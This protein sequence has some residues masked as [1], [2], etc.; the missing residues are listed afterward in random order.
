MS[1]YAQS[2]CSETTQSS[3]LELEVEKM[4]ILKSEFVWWDVEW[5]EGVLLEQSY[6]S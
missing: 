5:N 2:D 4:E 1:P 3:D 6:I